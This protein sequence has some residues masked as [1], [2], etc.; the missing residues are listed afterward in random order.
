[1]EASQDLAANSEYEFVQ[2][3]KVERLNLWSVE[4][5]YLYKV[6]STVRQQ[7]RVVDEYDTP[8][9][10]REIVFDADKGFLP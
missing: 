9:G 2:Q 10:I 3:V 8:L 5:P 7:D 4:N 1:M 6:R